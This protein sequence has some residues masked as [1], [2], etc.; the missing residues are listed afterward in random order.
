ML[1]ARMYRPTAV[2]SILDWEYSKG[3]MPR[4]NGFSSE[5]NAL[6]SQDSK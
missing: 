2:M 5:G 6:I 1:T 3:L 4:I